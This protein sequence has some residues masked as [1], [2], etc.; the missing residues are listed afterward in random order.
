MTI[1]R[2]DGRAGDDH[3]GVIGLGYTRYRQPDP[4][5]AALIQRFLG[6]AATVLNV[7]AGTGNYEPLDRHVTA[8]EPSAAMRAARPAHLAQAIDAVAERLPFAD[9]QF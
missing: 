1:R 2:P 8:V 6:D 7:G 3:Y 4:R 9:R 5:I